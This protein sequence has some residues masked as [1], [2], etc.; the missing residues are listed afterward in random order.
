MPRVHGLAAVV[1]G[2]AL[3]W[4]YTWLGDLYRAVN[5]AA[6]IWYQGGNILLAGLFLHGFWRLGRE[7]APELEFFVESCVIL[8]A[9]GGLFLALT[10]WLR[11]HNWTVRIM[12]YWTWYAAPLAAWG[13]LGLPTRWRW[14]LLLSG[15]FL[16]AGGLQHVVYA[17]TWTCPAG[18]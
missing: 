1:V 6:L 4:Q 17:P 2:M 3:I 15:P 14:G 12:T 7:S 13:W 5:P 11:D 16:L 10:P 9:L 8:M 18:S